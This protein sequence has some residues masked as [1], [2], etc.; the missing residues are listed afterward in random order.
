MADIAKITKT[1]REEGCPDEVINRVRDFLAQRP[2]ATVGDVTK[3]LD[4]VA[5]EKGYTNY[6]QFKEAGFENMARDPVMA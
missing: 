5:V 3:L 2:G 6:R 1:L 4:Q